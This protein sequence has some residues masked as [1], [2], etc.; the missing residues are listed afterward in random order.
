MGIW[1]VARSREIEFKKTSIDTLLLPP[2]MFAF[3]PAGKLQMYPYLILLALTTII[4]GPL[5]V[6]HY[7][8]WDDLWMNDWI[9]NGRLDY[10]KRFLSDLGLNPCYYYF[11]S[12]SVFGDSGQAMHVIGFVFIYLR[13]VA[14]YWLL[15]HI[16]QLSA[17][18]VLLAAGVVIAFPSYKLVGTA[19]S[20]HYLW[21]PVLFFL[22]A[23]LALKSERWGGIRHWVGR[24]GAI[25]AFITSFCMS[26]LLVF[27]GGFFLI[28]M[29]CKQREAGLP[30]SIL[31]RL[32]YALLPPLYFAWKQ[33]F[34]PTGGAYADYNKVS[35]SLESL[36][37][38]MKASVR[39][40]LIAPFTCFD[41]PLAPP[42]WLG[43]TAFVIVGL[44]GC[45][46]T[47]AYLQR[48]DGD[49]DAPA[50]NTVWVC[51]SGAV[52]LF[53]ALFPYVAVGKP[54]TAWGL[55]TNYSVLMPLPVGLLVVALARIV[56]RWNPV[57]TGG[58]LAMV[59]L[60]FTSN[61]WD[62]Y[63]SLEALHARNESLRENYRHIA[64][65]DRYAVA[66][67]HQED[68]IPHTPDQVNFWIWTYLMQDITHGPRALAIVGDKSAAQPIPV[69]VVRERIHSTTLDFALDVDADGP[70]IL[71][72]IHPPA[73]RKTAHHLGARYLYYRWF[74]PAKLPRLLR[75]SSVLEW[76]VLKKPSPSGQ[77]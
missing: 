17:R 13:G 51:L 52:L 3:R 67:V 31:R 60:Q 22:A 6:T 11:A 53:L 23:L 61:W 77:E 37:T 27:Y 15:R 76:R 55:G 1:A 10:L 33:I 72:V 48:R 56:S 59:F 5:L 42:A 8:V 25:L 44:A 19:A 21:P 47:R 66:V 18:E 29:R 14:V 28:L 36:R 35:L 34:T 49:R 46:I 40:G 9:D 74:K 64:D 71:I 2:V 12:L 57:L 73:D 39:E 7:V 24:G 26:S 20:S 43:I 32:D 70:Q 58:M 16:N 62:N 65:A 69:E 63:L 45:L 75:S 30:R 38:G 4:H 68:F 41:L 50:A 54:P